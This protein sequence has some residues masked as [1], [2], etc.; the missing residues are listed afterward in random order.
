MIKSGKKKKAIKKGKDQS[1]QRQA[2][3][4]KDIEAQSKENRSGCSR[5][6]ESKSFFNIFKKVKEIVQSDNNLENKLKL[7]WNLLVQEF[8]LFIK[9]FVQNGDIC[10]T[11]FSFLLNG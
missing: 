4:A 11:I 2:T 8:W 1:H 6:S 5:T 3:I 7:I 9:N 10:K